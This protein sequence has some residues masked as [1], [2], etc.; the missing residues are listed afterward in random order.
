MG[1]F[2]NGVLI[3]DFCKSDLERVLELARLCFAREF[4]FMGLNVEHLKERIEHFFGF[5]GRLMLLLLR[6][7]RKEPFRFFVADIGGNVVGTTM[8]SRD[9]KVG[10]ISTVMVHP[11]YRGRGIAKKLLRTAISYIRQRG[12][13]RAVLHVDSINK[14]AKNLYA[15]LGF[16]EFEKMV[17]MVGDV[18]TVSS[19]QEFMDAVHIR[20]FQK[21]DIDQVYELAKSC[22]DS[23]H[24]K[25]FGFEK[26]DL[27]GSF[28][29][30]LFNVSNEIKITATCRNKVIGYI[31]IV[32]T[33]ATG[34][35]QISHIYV[36]PEMR[37]MGIEELLIRAGMDTARKFGVEKVLAMVSLRRKELISAMKR[38]RFEEKFVV[39]GMF[40]EVA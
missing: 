15:K 13:K 38:C 5:T 11:S 39:D 1:K 35:G 29:A 27:K 23:E 37:S 21:K 4:E 22:E 20:N 30:R 2:A 36:H 17:Y 24:L 12:M 19:K 16:E 10:Y 28:L 32:Y 31:N 9:G 14:P 3:R 18:N 26:K 7:F 6:V 34:T 25:V 40:L 8:I 33:T